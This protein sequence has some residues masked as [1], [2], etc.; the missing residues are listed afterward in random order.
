M[1]S[2]PSDRAS[3]Q[4]EGRKERVNRELIEL[5]NG[6]RVALPGVQVLFAFL[7]VLPFQQGFSEISQTARIVYFTA[8]L[9]SAAAGALLITPSIYH[10][11]NFRRG[12]KEKML[13]DSNVLVIIGTTFT[14]VGIAL[15]IFL[16]ADV[17]FDEAVALV[18]LLATVIVYGGLWGVLPLVR[19]QRP[20]TDDIEP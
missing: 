12:N 7:L 11:L 10:R 14:G 3:R 1:T 8:L 19:R 9:T 18:A 13:H 17:V 4:R 6:I 20:D 2:E 16:V 5:L 15:A